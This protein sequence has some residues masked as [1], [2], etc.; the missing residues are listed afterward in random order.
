MIGP[1]AAGKKAAEF[2]YRVYGVPGAVIAGAGGV[3]SVVVAKKG[4]EAI[5]E[6]GDDVRS[7]EDVE[8]AENVTHIEIEEEDAA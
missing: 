2:G 6:E 3:A 1:L 8:G 7:V 5:A 4:I